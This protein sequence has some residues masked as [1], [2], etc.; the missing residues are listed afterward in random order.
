MQITRPKRIFLPEDFTI[1]TWENLE[2][3]FKCLL[4][5]D[6]STKEEFEIWLAYKSELDAVIEEDAAW[7]YIHMS[8]DTKDEDRS[9][10]YDFFITDIQPKLAPLEDQLNKKIAASPFL[11]EL[12]KNEDYYIYFRSIKKAI[13]LYC[14]EN[15]PLESEVSQ[16]AHQY[17]AI[18]GAQTIVYDGQELTLQRAALHLKNQD[19]SVR[20]EVFELI[21]ERRKIDQKALDDL[22]DKLIQKRH[23]IAINAGYE[24]Y[25][26]YKFDALGRFDYTK[27][28]CFAFHQSIKKYIVPIVKHF[29]ETQAKRL[30][31]TKLKPWDSEVD[32]FGREPLKPFE[33]AEALTKGTIKAFNHLDTYFGDCIQ[34]MK[35]MKHLD[36]DSKNGKSPGGY[37]YPLYEIGVPFIFMNS[38]G[39]Q[40]DL[41]TMVHEGGHAIHSFLSRDLKLT[42]FKNLPSEVAEL[43]S[44]SMELLSMEYWNEFYTSEEDLNRAKLE[45]IESVIKVLPWIATIDEFQHWIYTHPTHSQEERKTKWNEINSSY[46]TG[47]VDWTGYEEIRTFSWQRQLH[48]YEVPFYYIEYGIAQLGAISI[49]KNSKQDLKK[50]VENYKKALRLGY[51]KSIPEIYK[52]AG[53][54]FDFSDNYVKE[55]ANFVVN[56]LNTIEHS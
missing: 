2:I 10:A 55:L 9:K 18:S 49:W 50:A 23:Q 40:R 5:K 11:G 1:T 33:D 37:N 32:P 16:L 45:Q 24:N 30:N 48:L 54:S 51:S 52:S 46:G 21:A 6:F 17:G 14:D 36:L 41:T 42:G 53:I 43:A 34:T 22:F 56:E 31:K 26:D 8:I 25:R 44:M 27:E 28:D 20:K 15:V 47:V 12:A 3:Y 38:V 39:S 29:N 4:E 35:E 19:E 13:D 7:R